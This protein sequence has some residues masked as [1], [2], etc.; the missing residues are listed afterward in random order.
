MLWGFD[1]QTHSRVS[2]FDFV[3]LVSVLYLSLGG[4]VSGASIELP[5]YCHIK[6][7][8][9]MV[10]VLLFEVIGAILDPLTECVNVLVQF[11]DMH[12]CFYRVSFLSLEHHRSRQTGRV[13]FSFLWGLA[14][15][16]A[17]SSESGSEVSCFST[18]FLPPVSPLPCR[19][20]T[21]ASRLRVQQACSF[22]PAHSFVYPFF[23]WSKWRLI[24]FLSLRRA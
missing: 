6:S 24:L 1:L 5:D 3:S 7:D 17:L 10:R 2:T 16:L 13:F 12:L 21:P 20:Y 9:I 8:V 23:Y 4:D 22:S 15:S 19:K 14:S 18:A 11:L